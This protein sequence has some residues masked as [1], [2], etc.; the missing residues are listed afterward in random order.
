MNDAP[1]DIAP[2]ADP[3]NTTTPIRGKAL[4]VLGISAYYDRY[5][6]EKLSS[7]FGYSRINISNADGQRDNEFRV[8]QYASTNLLYNPV[9]NMMTGGEFIYGY[10]RNFRDG[11]HVP[12]YRIQFV[13]RYNFS[14]RIGG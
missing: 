8:G 12:D 9:K 3:S 6:N 4:P 13:F 1:A 5:W 2:E 10:R 14:A 11:W 7:T